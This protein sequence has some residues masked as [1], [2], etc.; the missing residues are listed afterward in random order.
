[1]SEKELVIQCIPQITEMALIIKDM[2]AGQYEA[3]KQEHLE[4]VSRTCPRALGFIGNIFTVIEYAISTEYS[5]D[6]PERM[7]NYV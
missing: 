3:F 6:E 2:T 1:M 7:G 5:D 4:E